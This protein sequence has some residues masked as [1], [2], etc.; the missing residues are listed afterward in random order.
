MR[1]RS[2][3]TS[4]LQAVLDVRRTR[5]PH[6]R[7]AASP[8]KRM[9]DTDMLTLSQLSDRELLARLPEA[10]AAERTAIAQMIAYLAE[11]DH[12]RLCLGEAC[13]SLFSFCMQRLGYSENEAQKRI[14]VARVCQRLPQVLERR[15]AKAALEALRHRG[16]KPEVEQLLRA[17]LVML[18]P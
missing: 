5:S 15:G 7:A 2:V 18:V 4:T 13:S 9:V 6:W 1:M 11:V 10:R 12:R 16:M 14:R 8:K 3:G 17:A